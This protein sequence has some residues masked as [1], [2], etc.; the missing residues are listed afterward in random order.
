MH[1]C[2]ERE[3]EREQE[4]WRAGAAYEIPHMPRRTSPQKKGKKKVAE[5]EKRESEQKE[6]RREECQNAS[7][8]WTDKGREETLLHWKVSARLSQSWRLESLLLSFVLKCNFLSDTCGVHAPCPQLRLWSC[9][10]H[11]ALSSFQWD[12]G[13]PSCF[14]LQLLWAATDPCCSASVKWK[15]LLLCVK[16]KYLI[17]SFLHTPEH[18]PCVIPNALPVW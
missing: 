18:V 10:I 9:L 1:Q 17:Y 4:S 13:V 16:I 14:N 15:C 8:G 3:G 5:K 6:K 7:L 12:V 2:K 11:K